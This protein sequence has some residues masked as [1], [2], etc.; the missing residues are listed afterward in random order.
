MREFDLSAVSCLQKLSKFV[1]QFSKTT[2]TT[3]TFIKESVIVTK[4]GLPRK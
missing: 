2:T 3:T 1:P 4:G